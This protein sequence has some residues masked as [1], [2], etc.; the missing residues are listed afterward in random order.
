MEE[1]EFCTTTGSFLSRTLLLHRLKTNLTAL[2]TVV[3]R[4]Q[5]YE[6]HRARMHWS[7]ICFRMEILPDRE[8]SLYSLFAGILSSFMLWLFQGIMLDDAFKRIHG[9]CSNIGLLGVEYKV[10]LALTCVLLCSIFMCGVY[11]VVHVFDGCLSQQSESSR[12]VQCVWCLP[13]CVCALLMY[14]WA[15]S[16]FPHASGSCVESRAYHRYVL[17]CSCV[18]G[19]VHAMGL[20]LCVCSIVNW[21][22]AVLAWA[23][24]WAI[25]V[26]IISNFFPY[27]TLRLDSNR[28]RFLLLCSNLNFSP[29]LFFH[30][31][32][33]ASHLL[34]VKDRAPG[35][36]DPD[37][38]LSDF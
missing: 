18:L 5:T 29:C 2:Q 15:F 4:L 24:Q 38:D 36:C 35:S 13:V 28:V 3:D 14:E 30:D 32:R 33:V 20:I 34:L 25:P 7:V 16:V 22:L 9:V 17:T 8:G 19:C 6:W 27:N 10:A 26:F 1:N 12:V 11:L 21:V 31:T 37:G 23:L